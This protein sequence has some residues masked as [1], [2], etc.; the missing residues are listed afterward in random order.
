MTFALIGLDR[1]VEESEESVGLF[2]A[3]RR[4]Q[5]LTI[6]I[7]PSGK[8]SVLTAAWSPKCSWCDNVLEYARARICTPHQHVFTQHPRETP[9]T[10]AHM[11][12]QAH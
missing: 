1:G 12:T 6:K 8:C 5:H 4:A 11:D 7:R 9:G 10:E 2:G 3:T